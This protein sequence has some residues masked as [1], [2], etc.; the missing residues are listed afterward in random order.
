VAK[1]T[2]A[3]IGIHRDNPNNPNSHILL[4]TRSKPA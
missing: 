1:G 4:T 2:V 3:D